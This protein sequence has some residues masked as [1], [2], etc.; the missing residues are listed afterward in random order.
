MALQRGAAPA[1]LA[2]MPPPLACLAGVHPP[3]RRDEVELELELGPELALPRLLRRLRRWRLQPRLDLPQQ[4]RR[5]P[6]SAVVVGV[7]LHQL[8]CLPSASGGRPKLVHKWKEVVRAIPANRCLHLPRSPI[9][10]QLRRQ[11]PLHPEAPRLQAILLLPLPSLPRAR[12]QLHQRLQHR[13]QQLP[14]H[15]LRQWQHQQMGQC[16]C[17]AHRVRRKQQR[18]EQ[19]EG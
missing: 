7:C 9:L 8:K 10:L 19:E 1:P 5:G 6:R 4:R 11:R 3:P 13:Q 2:P 16:L 15:Q 17:L 14:W 12:R 18:Q